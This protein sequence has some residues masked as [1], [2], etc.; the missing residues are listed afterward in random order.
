MPQIRLL[1]S[2]LPVI[3]QPSSNLLYILTVLTFTFK[4]PS[5]SSYS[6]SI[7]WYVV[8]IQLL[9]LLPS[10]LSLEFYCFGA[11]AIF[12]AQ[13]AKTNVIFSANFNIQYQTQLGEFL[14]TK[15][16]NTKLPNLQKLKTQFHNIFIVAVKVILL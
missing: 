10:K 5:F 16:R 4:G 11:Q 14:N 2:I 6:P 12:K 15:A 7:F 8:L 3:V 13:R 1:E 9:K